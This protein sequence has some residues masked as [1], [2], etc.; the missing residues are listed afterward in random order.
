MEACAVAWQWRVTLSA[1]HVVAG[2]CCVQGYFEGLGFEIPAH[3]NPADAYLDIIAGAIQPQS[4]AALDIAACWHT[5]QQQQGHSSSPI[6]AAGRQFQAA[7]EDISGLTA[8]VESPRLLEGCP[9]QD[10]AVVAIAAS[11]R[12]SQQGGQPAARVSTRPGNCLSDLIDSLLLTHQV[13][14]FGMPQRGPNVCSAATTFTVPA[15]C[16]PC[17][18]RWT[19]PVAALSKLPQVL[20]LGLTL[21]VHGVQDS[22]SSMR[23][24]VA[25]QLQSWAAVIAARSSSGSRQHPGSRPPVGRQQSSSSS[26]AAD[27]RPPGFVRQYWLVLGRA[28]LMRTREPFLVF[29][30]YM[31]FAVTGMRRQMLADV[32]HYAAAAAHLLPCALSKRDCVSCQLRWHCCKDAGLLPLSVHHILCMSHGRPVG[33]SRLPQCCCWS[34]WLLCRHV[35]GADE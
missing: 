7:A 18:Q 30:E 28:A 32:Q 20:L 17:V 31:I 13:Q 14:S 19:Q 11:R 35:C 4:G 3:M 29:I 8:G 15:C 22:I 1:T 5:R 23:N 6:P 25:E 21:L 2:L 10:S 27:R 26:S 9:E 12:A 33:H 16:L 24:A 34:G